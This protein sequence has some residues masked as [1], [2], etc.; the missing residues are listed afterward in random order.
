MQRLHAESIY[1]VHDRKS[2]YR[3]WKENHVVVIPYHLSHILIT[4]NNVEAVWG[5][6]LNLRQKVNKVPH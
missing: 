3:A 2:V 4:L 5:F 1:D 6:K